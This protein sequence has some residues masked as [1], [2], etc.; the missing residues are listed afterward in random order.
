M[1]SNSAKKWNILVA[2]DESG[3]LEDRGWWMGDNFM[4]AI[5]SYKRSQHRANWEIEMINDPLS[6]S[7]PYYKI[8]GEDGAVFEHHV[9]RLGRQRSSIGF[10]IGLRDVIQKGKT[11]L[12]IIERLAHWYGIIHGILESIQHLIQNSICS[13]FMS[14]SKISI[15]R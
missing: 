8:I 11:A 2:K 3:S 10:K 6:V 4:H 9:Q 15:S 7:T 14:R 5:L 1:S 13:C 12:S